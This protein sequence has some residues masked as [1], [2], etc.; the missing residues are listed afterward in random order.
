MFVSLISN[1]VPLLGSSYLCL[2]YFISFCQM[3]VD[4]SGFFCSKNV[5]III[6]RLIRMI[7]FLI[8][9]M[10]LFAGWIYPIFQPILLFFFWF[11]V[12]RMCI[13]IFLFRFLCSV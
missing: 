9:L 11:I 3:V 5:H 10:F 8:L 4:F 6:T 7:S 13:W 12:N 2:N 1:N